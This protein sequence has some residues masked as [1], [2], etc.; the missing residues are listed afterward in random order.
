MNAAFGMKLNKFRYLKDQVPRQLKFTTTMNSAGNKIGQM[1]TNAGLTNDQH[2]IT[3]S[4]PN[5]DYTRPFPILMLKERK[6]A[7]IWLCVQMLVWK[8]L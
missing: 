2:T 1:R 8:I 4:N 3:S 7:I 5:T 6:L